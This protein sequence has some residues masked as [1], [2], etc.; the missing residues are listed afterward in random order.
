VIAL[1]CPVDELS[2]QLIISTVR[3]RFT[4]SITKSL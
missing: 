3:R 4:P 2:V 1:L